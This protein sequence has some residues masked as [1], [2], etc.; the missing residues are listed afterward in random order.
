MSKMG[1][2]KPCKLIL[3]LKI[4]KEKQGMTLT[5]L[6]KQLKFSTSAISNAL[7]GINQPSLVMATEIARHLEIDLADYDDVE[8]CPT[9]RKGH[10]KKGSKYSREKAETVDWQG[11]DF[12]YM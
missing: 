2:N 1:K 9:T 10:S 8:Y 12:T 5:A 3:A 6:A 11:N 7:H 4:Y